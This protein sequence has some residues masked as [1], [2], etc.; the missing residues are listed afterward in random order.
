VGNSGELLD[1]RC[2]QAQELLLLWLCNEEGSDLNVGHL[3]AGGQ[4]RLMPDE[5][6]ISITV[7]GEQPSVPVSAAVN[8]LSSNGH[9]TLLQRSHHY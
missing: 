1:Q 2:N 5:Y 9:A 8:L 6:P 4:I 3:A 7:V